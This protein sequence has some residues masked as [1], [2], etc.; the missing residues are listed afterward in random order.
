MPNDLLTLK[1][2]SIELNERLSGGKIEKVN[3][4]EKD[5]IT[6]SVRA[7]GEK[8]TLAISC[9]ANNPR[10]HL[11]KIKKENPITAPNFCMH[12]RKYLTS[13][14]IE[15]I[16]LVAQ[17]RIFDIT[18]ISKNE[19]KDTIKLHLLCEMMGRYSNILLVNDK[20]I[21]KDVIKQASFDMATKRCIMP[22]SKYTYPEQNK[23]LPT[24]YENIRATLL[25][26]NG[27]NLAKYMISNIGGLAYS[28]SLEFVH[29]CKINKNTTSLNTNDIDN[30]VSLFKKYF[31]DC[32]TSI[33]SPQ[34]SID[35]NENAIDYYAFPYASEDCVYKQ[36][37]SLSNAIE[38]TTYKKEIESRHREKCKHLY[39]AVKKYRTRQEKK[40]AKANE[41]L[42]E[43]DNMEK[44]KKYGELIIANLYK[45]EK[46]D[47]E[48]VTVDYYEEDMPT[49]KIPLN[50]QYSPSKVAQDYFKK[51]NKL[52]RTL[53]VI[54][55]QIDEIE[56]NIKYI[57]SVSAHLEFCTKANDIAQL[58]EELCQVGAL[59][60]VKHK[61]PKSVKASSP[62]IYEYLGYV[63]A[64]GKNNIQ[65]D[66]L[67][68][69]TASGN[70]MWL[71]TLNYHGSHVIIFTENTTP[72]NEVIQF[73]A[74][75]AGYYS[76]GNQND[77]V[78][79]DYTL[80]RYVRKNSQGGLGMV[81][82][83][84]QNTAYVT[85]KEH[86]EYIKQ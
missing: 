69:K 30:I 82:Y 59:R 15:S 31:E 58:E 25:N 11:T 2:L 40:L 18:I 27:N 4:P 80:K 63:I 54:V 19:L 24:D 70:D 29:I 52:K 68:H 74:E 36:M 12:L 77:K 81:T 64:V 17:D 42:A 28:S 22:T 3:Q 61:L 62:I 32:N 8:Y 78:A 86:K 33:Y 65:N 48:L 20:M 83:I 76:S 10:I 56:N 16:S 73:G 1:A 66:K 50:P 39:N 57:D 51:Y 5:E 84:N 75:L 71:H 14:I 37:D 38:Y 26:Y 35:Q 67:T 6:L 34:V 49:I 13:G 72:P 53:E 79:V 60:V 44:Y 55:E 7:K 47:S 85:P 43:C 41:K 46:G 9:N 45:L 23:I 21:I